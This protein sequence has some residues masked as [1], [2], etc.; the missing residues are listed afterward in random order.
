M[1]KLGEL[2]E[3]ECPLCYR[4]TYNEIDEEY[5]SGDSVIFDCGYCKRKFCATIEVYYN[6]YNPRVIGVT[7]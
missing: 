1:H 4:I 3:G 6:A 2:L 5:C 7:D